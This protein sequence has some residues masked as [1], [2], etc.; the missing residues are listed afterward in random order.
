MLH[1]H[2]TGALREAVRKHLKTAV[3]HVREAGPAESSEGGDA[4]HGVLPGVSA[5]RDASRRAARCSLL[6][7]L[8]NIAGTLRSSCGAH[9]GGAGCCGL[10]SSFAG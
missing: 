2:G 1:G 9:A 8:W 5:R 7:Q 3:P 6:S 4:R 10:A